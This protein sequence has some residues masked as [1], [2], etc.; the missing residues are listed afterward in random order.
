MVSPKID[1]NQLKK[2]ISGLTSIYVF[3][4][5]FEDS[6]TSKTLITT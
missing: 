5:T 6:L 1:Q 4:R 2:K 3:S